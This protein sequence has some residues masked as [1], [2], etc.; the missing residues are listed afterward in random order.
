MSAGFGLSDGL[1]RQHLHWL[2]RSARMDTSK[3]TRFTT[4]GGFF[5]C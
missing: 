1:S 5:A 4:S 2:G 3:C